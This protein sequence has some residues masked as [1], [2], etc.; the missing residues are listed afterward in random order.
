MRSFAVVSQLISAD[1]YIDIPRLPAGLFV[2][3][4]RAELRDRVPR[5]ED[6][7]QGPFWTIAGG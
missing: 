7:P 6:T 5:V 4:C 3:N 2:E 1:S